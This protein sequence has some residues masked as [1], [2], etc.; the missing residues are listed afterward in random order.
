MSEKQPLSRRQKQILDFIVDEIRA[1]GYGPT[2][3]EIVVHVNN[4]E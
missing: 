1:H 4:F 3:R 2:V